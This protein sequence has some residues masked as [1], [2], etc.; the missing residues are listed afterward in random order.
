L[1]HAGIVF[2]CT[3]KMMTLYAPAMFYEVPYSNLQNVVTNLHVIAGEHPQSKL[4]DSVRCYFAFRKMR[5]SSRL[6]IDMTHRIESMMFEIYAQWEPALRG[7][8]RVAHEND[9]TAK[10]VVAAARLNQ[11]A[12]FQCY[13][14]HMQDL[15]DKI[16]D[17][18]WIQ[19]ADIEDTIRRV[20]GFEDG[21]LWDSPNNIR[22]I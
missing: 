2:R 17:E 20:F 22:C 21:P 9:R 12:I 7:I 14:T 15:A 16:Q 19:P 11:R 18:N 10:Y 3:G 1:I 4:H 8:E 13:A 6:D 5:W